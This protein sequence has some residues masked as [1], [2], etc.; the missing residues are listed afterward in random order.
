MGEPSGEV[1]EGRCREKWRQLEEGERIEM[2]KGCSSEV[3]TAQ[4][5]PQ[6]GVGG[7]GGRGTNGCVPLPEPL[8]RPFIYSLT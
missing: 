7:V 5:P 3:F 8:S 1:G 4:L 2:G 6:A